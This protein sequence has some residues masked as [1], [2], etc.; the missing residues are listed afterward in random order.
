MPLFTLIVPTHDRPG[1]ISRLLRFLSQQRVEFPI[2]VLDSSRQE[3]QAQNAGSVVRENLDLRHIRYET[4]MEVFEKILSGVD[5]VST[6]YVAFCSDDDVVL[7]RGLQFSIKFLEQNPEY[8]A[9]HGSYF[10]FSENEAFELHRLCY[11]RNNLIADK[12][13]NRIQSLLQNYEATSYAVHRTSTLRRSLT[14]ASQVNPIFWKEIISCVGT[15]LIGKVARLPCLSYGR[16][17]EPSF[18]FSDWHPLQII[19]RSPEN[20][21]RQYFLYR[22]TILSCPEVVSEIEFGRI[23]DVAHLRYLFTQ[24]PSPVLDFLIEG[25]TEGSDD[26]SLEKIAMK[27]WTVPPTIERRTRSPEPVPIYS[28]SLKIFRNLRSA[29]DVL[30]NQPTPLI[31]PVDEITHEICVGG[32]HRMYRICEEFRA[33]LQLKA[34]LQPDQEIIRLIETLN[35]FG[36]I[37]RLGED[38]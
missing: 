3:I 12:I 34:Q 27:R 26:L 14:L 36:P 4:T 37:E 19:N 21:L 7:P 32:A 9:A 6:P 38:R 25:M 22:K 13:E 5:M 11:W 29:W 16:N 18:N 33:D 2:W 28:K 17:N 24:L 35:A 1:H 30:T 23:L 10:D 8:S 20:F 31:P 15:L